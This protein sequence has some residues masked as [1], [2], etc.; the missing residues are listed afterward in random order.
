[1]RKPNLESTSV[2]PG[3]LGSATSTLA[4]LNAGSSPLA[5]GS[6]L[7]VQVADQAVE[8][9]EAITLQSNFDEIGLDSVDR[10]SLAGELAEG[11]SRPVSST[12]LFDNQSID[13]V[14][15]ALAADSCPELD[16]I[17]DMRAG[18]PNATPVYLLHSIAGDLETMGDLAARFEGRP[19]YGIQ[20]SFG[21]DELDGASV[22]GM[23]EVYVKALVAH[24]PSGRFCVVG[25]SYGARVAFEVA[26]QL[27]SVGR[28]IELLGILDS[29][30]TAPSPR[31]SVGTFMAIPAFAINL[32]RWIRDDLLS[33]SPKYH[34]RRVLRRLNSL[35]KR[36]WWSMKQK[37]RVRFDLEDYFDLEDIPVQ[38]V[39]RKESNLRNWSQ[40][41]PETYA[42]IV[43]LFRTKTR[44][45]FH[46]LRDRTGGWTP[47]ADGGVDVH[48]VDG[49]HT[50]MVRNPH[51]QGLARAIEALLD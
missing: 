51:A 49:H 6:W 47:Y 33:H 50:N 14:L 25:H 32:P 18:S 3:P 1:M 30:P 2:D 38:V 13:E 39:R 16:C 5:I 48:Y 42:G 27:R 29:W 12:L 8:A 45:L 17:V 34:A 11:L 15:E 35:Q 44:P 36:G 9:S 26:R 43:T 4:D 37:P 21:V 10:F 7:L 24:R 31:T 41:Q 20:Q 46:S 19:V 23:A 28:E 40:Y 22:E